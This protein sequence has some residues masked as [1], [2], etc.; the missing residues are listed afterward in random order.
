LTPGVV[1]TEVILKITDGVHYVRQ[2]MGGHVHA[3]LL[4]DGNGII[5]IDALYDTEPH[6]ILDE[7]SAMGW[8][9][10]DLKNIIATH[11]HRSHIGGMAELKSRTNARVYAH[12][13]E[14]GIIEDK[15]KAT[16]VSV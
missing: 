6:R 15:G 3:F 16:K 4:D 8:Q 9:P 1:Q 7:I 5:L 11:A 10:S 13:W 14:I 12:E 2:N